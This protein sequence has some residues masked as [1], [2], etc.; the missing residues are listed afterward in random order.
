MRKSG[1]MKN[2]RFT[3]LFVFMFI[4]VGDLWLPL[5]RNDKASMVSFHDE[6]TYHVYHSRYNRV[7]LT[8][9]FLKN[10]YFTPLVNSVIRNTGNIGQYIQSSSRGPLDSPWPMMSHDIRRTGRS[11]YNTTQTPEGVEIWRFGAS[12]SFD[13]GVVVDDKGLLYFGCIDTNVY[14]TDSNGTLRW[15]TNLYRCVESTPAIDENGIIY[16]GTALNSNCLF[17]LYSNNGTVKWSYPTGNYVDSSPAIGTDGTIYFG[18]YN[19]YFT[20]LHPDGRVKWRY[21]TG[22]VIT[23]SP[24]IGPDGTVYIGSQDSILYAFFPD[25]GSVKWKFYTGGWVRVS[26]CVGDD[27]T[28]FCVSFDNYLYA[29]YPDNGTMKWKTFVN[30]GTNPTIGPDGTIYAGW[31]VL[32]AVNPDG[33]VKWTF[34]GYAYIE[35]GT[36]CTS[37]EGIIYFGTTG[38]KIVAVNPNGTL[39]WVRDLTHPCQSPP[40]IAADGTI[41][42]GSE[43]PGAAIHAYGQGPLRAEAYGPYE[44]LINTSI[45]FTSDGFGGTPPYDFLWEFGDHQTSNEQNP[46]HMYTGPGIFNVILT[47]QDGS[48]NSTIDNATV[49]I[50]YP[51]PVV[52]ITKPNPTKGG[53]YVFDRRILP[54]PLYN[55]LICGPITI[56]ATA[57]QTPLGISHVDF[58]VDD[59]FIGTDT[60]SP[61]S[62]VW[63]GAFKPRLGEHC[64]VVRGFDNGGK[65]SWWRVYIYKL[66]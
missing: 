16:I 22:D 64:I 3:V 19:G 17:A 30:A 11:P 56:E 31:D 28:V 58:Y 1:K 40:A 13:G 7:E 35:G 12:D 8:D 18:D 5:V 42:I 20:A 33:T 66:F 10:A 29:I 36:P 2:S 21:H 53:L 37:K 45:Q 9:I 39:R 60:T 6:E 34:P 61:Y 48:E 15:K 23:G 57:T 38:D 55:I 59:T 54:I 62:Y 25:N 4:V 51:G 26:P 47:I 50:T 63:R 49:S 14:S 46:K 52:H 27:G 24:A 65:S 32:Y 43:S 44:G 41:Y